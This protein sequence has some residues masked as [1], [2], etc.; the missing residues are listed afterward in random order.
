MQQL[1]LPTIPIGATEING[2]TAV[3]RD[4][5][6]WTYYLGCYPIFTHPPDDLQQFRFFTSHL[7]DSG[8]CRQ[9]DIINTFGVSKSSVARSLRKLREGRSTSLF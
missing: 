1:I 3:W 4:E 9:V 5:L 2:L 6:R 8:R 7:I